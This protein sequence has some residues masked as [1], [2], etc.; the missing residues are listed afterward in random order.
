MTPAPSV[1]FTRFFAAL[2][3]EGIP[4]VVLH[5]YEALPDAVESD[6]DYAVADSDLPR[7]QPLLRRVVAENGWILTQVLQ[8]EVCA[9]YMVVNAAEDPRAFLKLDVCSHYVRNGCLFLRDDFLL[10]GRRG[11]RGFHIPAPA[12]EFAYVLAK[13]FAKRKR[14]ADYLPRLRVLES[15]DPEGCDQAMR[16]LAGE[17]GRSAAAWLQTPAADWHGLGKLMQARHRYGATMRL[18]EVRRRLRRL[19]RPAG[20]HVAVLG[21]DG[22]G[23]STLLE[24]LRDVEAPFR[25]RLT[26]HFR[27]KFLAQAGAARPVVDPHALPPRGLLPS[28]L[29]TAYYFADQWLGYLLRVFPAKLQ[30]MLVVFDRNFDDLLVDARRYRMQGCQW[31]VRLLRRWVPQPD[32]TFILLADPQVLRQRKP[33]LPLGELVRQQGVLRE[34]ASTDGRH[35]AIDAA[36]PAGEVALEVCEVIAGALARREEERERGRS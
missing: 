16:L 11:R 33:E 27:P 24:R 31:L 26:F 10:W 32:L 6:V 22:V 20:L 9:F 17:T 12:A 21:S 18:R 3:A 7:V 15:E 14:I 29:K 25:G 2:E 4:S 5:S 28:L 34:L 13:T 23:K 35:R 1:V 19:S 36:R 8:H 30:S